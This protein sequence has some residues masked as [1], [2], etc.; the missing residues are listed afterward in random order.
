MWNIGCCY[1]VN[2]VFH[3]RLQASVIE[4]WNLAIAYAVEELQ[5]YRFN[6]IKNSYFLF[7]FSLKHES[8]QR[9]LH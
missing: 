2:I 7:L 9:E 1:M 4:Q 6:R 5:S 3:I 8:K